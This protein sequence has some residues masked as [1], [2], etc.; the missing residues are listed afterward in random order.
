MF[1]TRPVEYE[2]VYENRQTLINGCLSNEEI[3]YLLKSIKALKSPI[4][5]VRKAHHL[6]WI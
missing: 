2:T 3:E 6:I 5:S 1:C 4:I